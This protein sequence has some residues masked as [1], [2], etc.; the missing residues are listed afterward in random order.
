MMLWNST[1]FAE[2]AILT[3]FG[4]NSTDDRPSNFGFWLLP[5]VSIIFVEMILIE[6]G[7]I[8][9]RSGSHQDVYAHR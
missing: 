1:L 9:R 6:Y 7:P 8:A 5:L 2:P 3:G 4:L